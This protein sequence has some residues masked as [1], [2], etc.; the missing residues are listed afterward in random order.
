MCTEL[1]SPSSHFLQ[2]CHEACSNDIFSFISLKPAKRLL[3]LQKQLYLSM[4]VV[5]K[6]RIKLDESE[7]VR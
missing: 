1:G 7:N 2:P 5:N 4:I 3:L 6:L